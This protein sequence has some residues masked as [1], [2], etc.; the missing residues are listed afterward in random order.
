MKEEEAAR[1]FQSQ[2]VYN[3]SLSQQLE[4]QRLKSLQMQNE[5]SRSS[6]FNPDRINDLAASQLNIEEELDKIFHLL[7]G[8][9]II[10]IN[11]KENW[12]EPKDDRLKILSDYG[13]KQI[14]NIM[15]FYINKNTL[16]SFYDEETTNWKVKDFGEEL[17]DLM[18]TKHD[19]FFHYPSPE[20][21]YEKYLPIVKSQGMNI[22]D[23]ELYDKCIE[24]S[25]AERR[26]KIKH[27]PMIHKCLVDSVDSTYRRALGGRER[28]SL[29]KMIHVAQSLNNAANPFDQQKPSIREK[30]FG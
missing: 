19:K 5:T 29:R 15:Y 25:N 16:L 11:G 4:E 3:D 27:C 20:E 30:L 23:A 17:I 9:V 26:S 18:L 6:F 10:V 22:T 28:E 13:V 1:I 24:E 12:V 21:L 7:S 2:Q 14:M 8:H